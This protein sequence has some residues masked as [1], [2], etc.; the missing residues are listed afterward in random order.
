MAAAAARPAKPYMR[1][2][3]NT[4]N[5]TQ[6][7][8]PSLH[9]HIHTYTHTRSLHHCGCCHLH[10][11]GS[12]GA[13]ALAAVHP[14]TPTFRPSTCCLSASRP[15]PASPSF[16]SSPPHAPPAATPAPRG[17]RAP[18]H[19]SC[20]QVQTLTGEER[21]RRDMQRQHGHTQGDGLL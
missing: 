10:A 15:A 11:G 20:G 17:A 5:H 3:V 21:R 14:S 2:H 4:L 13:T 8:T 6:T 9:Q 19:G 7:R 12:Q 18:P 1:V 16:C